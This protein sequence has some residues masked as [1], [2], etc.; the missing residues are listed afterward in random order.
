MNKVLV[1]ILCLVL[2]LAGVVVPTASAASISTSSRTILALS[3]QQ[4]YLMRDTYQ[5]ILARYPTLSAFAA[6]TTDEIAT[7]ASLKK[8][9]AKY[10]VSVP[11]DANVSAAQTLAITAISVSNADTV[12]INL[13]QSTAVLMTRLSQTAD[14]RDVATAVA[15]IRTTSLG[16]HTT[17]FATEQSNVSTPAPVAP[18]QHIASFTTGDST[19]TFLTLL[20]DETVDVVEMA[21]GTYHLHYTVININRTRPVLVRPVAGTTVILSGSDLGTDPQFQFGDGGTAGNITMQGLIFDGFILGQQ[22]IIQALDSHDITLNDMVVR[23]SRANGTTAQPYHSWAIYISSNAT[24]H[25]TNFTANRWT[26][27]GSARGMSAL[28]VY[29]GSHVTAIGWSVSNAYYAVYASSSRGPLTDFVVDGWTI[30][31]T[32]APAWGTSNVS[33]A[34]ENSTGTYSNMHGTTSGVL[35][36]VGSP[37]LTDGGGNSL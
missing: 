25:S 4:E 27:D 18:A 8:I 31:N 26:V 30:S 32:G 12:A 19:A 14:N 9:F 10:R 15:A 23:N 34:V 20:A 29:G 28:Q 11:V 24:V 16:S 35:L 6:V 2:T 7:I 33:L 22:G 37:K 36:N 21:A 17:T 3:L 5:N 13:E 1:L